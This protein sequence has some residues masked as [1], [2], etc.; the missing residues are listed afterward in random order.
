M[1]FRK[2]LIKLKSTK[3]NTSKTRYQISLCLEVQSPKFK[4]TYHLERSEPKEFKST[5]HLDETERLKSFSH[6]ITSRKARG[7]R[8]LV[9]LAPRAKREAQSFSQPTSSSEAR[10]LKANLLFGNEHFLQLIGVIWL[11]V[12]LLVRYF[13][14]F[15]YFCK[16]LPDGDKLDSYVEVDSLF[17]LKNWLEI[18]IVSKVDSIST[19]CLTRKSTN[20]SLR[21]LISTCYF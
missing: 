18:E 2:E 8:V 6:P 21:S 15:F 13:Y 11:N 20:W 7:L 17:R 10:D 4:S 3:N 16:T 14:L 19:C 5:Y 1:R 12:L 9:N